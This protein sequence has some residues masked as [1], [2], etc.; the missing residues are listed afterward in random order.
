MRARALSR[1]PNAAE[2]YAQV[3]T[4]DL[5][6]QAGYQAPPEDTPEPPAAP[7]A[8][9]AP[10]AASGAAATAPAAAAPA[11][12][13]LA[14]A[15]APATAAAGIPQSELA[16]MISN[17]LFVRVLHDKKVR[18]GFCVATPRCSRLARRRR[19][20]HPCS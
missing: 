18:L 7:E 15:S 13:A 20:T 14:A 1:L 12:A 17:P 3:A 10:A 16:C 2:S 19:Y 9:A 6:A 5:P 11:A 8:G 4:E